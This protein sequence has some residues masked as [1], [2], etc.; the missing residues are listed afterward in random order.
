MAVS[1]EQL[2]RFQEICDQ[3]GVAIGDSTIPHPGEVSAMENITDDSDLPGIEINVDDHS[4]INCT[5]GKPCISLTMIIIFI[6]FHSLRS[7]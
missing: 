3:A 4:G 7:W 1:R 6:I 5:D 2:T